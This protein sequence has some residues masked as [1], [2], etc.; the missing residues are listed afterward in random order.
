[1]ESRDENDRTYRERLG[2]MQINVDQVG[3]ERDEVL[4]YFKHCKVG[5]F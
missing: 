1:M 4:P 2:K 3:K 5:R